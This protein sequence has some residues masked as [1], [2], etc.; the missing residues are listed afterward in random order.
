MARH[1]DKI[2]HK[3]LIKK[4]EGYG[5]QGNVLRWIAEW[6]DDRK[7]R[8]QLNGHRS[9]WTEVRTKGSVLEPLLLTIFNDDID[10]EILCET[11]KFTYDTKIASRVNTLND[12]RSMQ[13]TSDKLVAWANRWDMEF[14]VNKCGVEQCI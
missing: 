4:F 8:V 12:I 9:G 14:S 13:R 10:E 1:F 3:R 11:S 5:I 7:Q 2:P 6:L